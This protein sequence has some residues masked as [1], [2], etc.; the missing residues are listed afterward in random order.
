MYLNEKMVL[1][2]AAHLFKGY[3][4]KEEQ[5]QEKDKSI[6]GEISTGVTLL[7]KLFSPISA[8]GELSGGTSNSV[9]SERLY[10]LGGLHMSVLE[11]L[12]K[13]KNSQLKPLNISLHEDKIRD[14]S[15]LS[16]KV[17]L[18]PVDFYETIQLLSLLRPLLVKLFDEFGDKFLQSRQSLSQLNEI[19]KYDEMIG[20][21]LKSLED[22]YLKSRQLEMIMISP[23]NNKPLGVLDIPLEDYDPVEMKSKLN[24]GQFY[25]VGKLIRYIDKNSKLSLVQRSSFSQIILLFEKLISFSEKDNDV[26]DFRKQLKDIE[27]IVNKVIKLRLEGPAVRLLALSVSA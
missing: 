2:T 10:T 20:T 25:V 19:Q 23:K 6:N 15:F 3:S 1:N 27:D 13:G 7:G 11:S 17:I 12:K 22:D 24:D 9:K 21:L 8:K 14:S 4:L 26:K 16:S 5:F 18:K